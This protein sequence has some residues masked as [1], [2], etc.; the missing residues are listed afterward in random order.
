MR[1]ERT[2][3]QQKIKGAGMGTGQKLLKEGKAQTNGMF[4]ERAAAIRGRLGVQT[5]WCEKLF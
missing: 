3:E 4:E 5:T 1:H 2:R